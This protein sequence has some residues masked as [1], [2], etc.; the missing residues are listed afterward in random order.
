[1][2]SI[3]PAYVAWRADNSF[4]TRFLATIDCFKIPARFTIKLDLN[5]KLPF[6]LVILVVYVILIRALIA[7]QGRVNLIDLMFPVS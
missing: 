6:V 7:V 5:N 4:P 3:P 1:M 2:E